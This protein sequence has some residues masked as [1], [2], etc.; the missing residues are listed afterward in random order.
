MEVLGIDIGGSGI[1]GALVDTKRGVFIT[2]RKR[3]PTP[4]SLEPKDV[5]ATV[6]KVV[7][8]FDTFDGPIGI[9]FPA[10]VVN[11]APRTAFTAHHVAGWVGYPVAR[12][13]SEDLGRPVTMLND[14]DAAG[15]AEMRFGNGRGED[16]V[17][18][19]LTLGTGIG[20]ALFNDGAL[21]PNTEFGKIYLRGAEEVVE[22]YASSLARERE[23]LSWKAYAGRL[24]AYLR[25]MDWL[26]SPRLIILGGG[27]SKKSHK[28]LPHIDVD[29]KVIPAALRNRAGIIGAATAAAEGWRH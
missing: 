13:L 11:G 3:L 19:V 23:D 7:R 1:K 8:H 20:S 25:Y 2:D 14:A 6:R 26:F 17:V 22:Q 28:F 29:T 24:Q 27:I 12:R 18:L 15:I 21:V 5:L 9:G 16:A 10:V 4:D